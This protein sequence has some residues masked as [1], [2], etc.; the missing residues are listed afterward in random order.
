[1]IFIVLFTAEPNSVL[2]LQSTG[3]MSCLLNHSKKNI[4]GVCSL[5]LFIFTFILWSVEERGHDI[6]AHE[7]QQG[8]LKPSGFSDT[9][10]KHT[11]SCL[12]VVLHSVVIKINSIQ[13]VG[14]YS[15][16]SEGLVFQ[17]S[18]SIYL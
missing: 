9:R 17:M 3:S 12:V 2:A 1:M 7:C 11:R 14:F 16:I 15:E 10:I 4:P 5:I 8:S 13:S 18:G 6:K